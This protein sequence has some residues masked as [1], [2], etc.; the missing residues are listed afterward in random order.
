MG[1]RKS[2]H[3]LF[4]RKCNSVTQKHLKMYFR[5]SEN[6]IKRKKITLFYINIENYSLILPIKITCFYGRKIEIK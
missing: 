2:R 5:D 4:W 6:T 1:C 3:P